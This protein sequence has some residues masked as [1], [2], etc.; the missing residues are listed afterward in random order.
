ME[1]TR[2]R[3]T[4][5]LKRDVSDRFSACRSLKKD[6]PSLANARW[7]YLKRHERGVSWT[8]EDALT[9]ILEWLDENGQGDL[10]GAITKEEY[11]ELK[12]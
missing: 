11:N 9:Q 8:K 4:D 1:Q 3:W 10:V 6:L 5:Y 12:A 7:A 2:V